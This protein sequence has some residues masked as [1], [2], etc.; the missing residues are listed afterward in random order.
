MDETLGGALASLLEEE[1]E[2]VA[3]V[4]QEE[5]EPEA[6]PA[7]GE[8]DGE[9]ETAVTPPPVVDISD[10]DIET[11]IESAN[12]HFE[13]AQEAQQNGDWATYGEEL[14]ALEQD[15]ETLL[16]LSGQTP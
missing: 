16:E 2:D 12:T 6:E 7:T 14:E 13:A 1:P 10:T 4:I 9:V 3:E 15:L 11:L 8:P 5:L